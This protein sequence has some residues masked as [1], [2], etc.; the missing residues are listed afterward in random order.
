MDQTATPTHH[1]P[2][3]KSAPLSFKIFG[4]ILLFAGLG[5]AFDQLD[6]L[7]FLMFNPLKAGL[8]II[9]GITLFIYL[10]KTALQLFRLNEKSIRNFYIVVVAYALYTNFKAVFLLGATPLLLSSGITA[11][12]TILILCGLFFFVSKNKLPESS[13]NPKRDN[14]ILI[15][16]IIALIVGSSI[17]SSIQKSVNQDVEEKVF[18]QILQNQLQEPT[19]RPVRKP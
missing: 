13:K 17:Y 4:T 9:L 12:L 11:A 1:I 16:L 5:V 10:E 2:A 15:G 3:K 14:K 6:S 7:F 19:K 8:S 18:N